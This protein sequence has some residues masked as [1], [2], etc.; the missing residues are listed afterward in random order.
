VTLR[1]VDVAT[2]RRGG[3]DAPPPRETVSSPSGASVGAAHEA[4]LV[5]DLTRTQIV[6]YA[7]A[8]GDFHPM[9]SDETYACAMGMPGV[10]AHGMLTMGLAARALV[11]AVGAS[12]LAEYGA[13]FLR[14][15]WPGDTLVARV[16]LE[17]VGVRAE[18]RIGRYSLAV[19]NQRGEPVLTGEAH[20]WRDGSG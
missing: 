19:R 14:T 12:P 10:F 9:H 17:G 1:A 2:A 7:G 15:V 8:S 18:R 13:R 5:E 6:M 4:T 3:A 11:H 16:A 20:A